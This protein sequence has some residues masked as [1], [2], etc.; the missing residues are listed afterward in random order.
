[1]S[2]KQN[3]NVKLPVHKVVAALEAALVKA[4]ASRERDTAIVQEN[5]KA[6]EEWEL[7]VFAV[8]A[9][10]FDKAINKRFY[11]RSHNGTVNLDFDLPES[12]VPKRPEPQ[13]IE[14]TESCWD[15]E[16]E[17]LESTIRILKLTEDE[18]I[19]TSTY[20]AISKYL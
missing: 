6:I 17:E 13:G 14:N 8:A 16:I 10:N 11:Q 3:I 20:N 5:A 1:M 9:S 18:T 12:I 7:A 19:S 15:T 4:K 2:R